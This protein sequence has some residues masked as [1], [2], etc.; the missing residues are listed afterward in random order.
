LYLQWLPVRRQYVLA[1]VDLTGG[2]PM[3]FTL[4]GPNYAEIDEASVFP[5]ESDRNCKH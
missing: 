4:V 1:F 3:N 5:E 2:N